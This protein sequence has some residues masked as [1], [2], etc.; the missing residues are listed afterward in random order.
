MDGLQRRS[1]V[2]LLYSLSSFLV[3]TT[4]PSGIFG[5]ASSGRLQTGQGSPG[6][7]QPHARGPPSQGRSGW[8]SQTQR[9]S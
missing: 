2:R 9:V 5:T 3:S 6:A 4:D 7:P 1:L 8:A